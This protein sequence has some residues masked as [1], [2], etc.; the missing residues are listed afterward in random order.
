MTTIG[1]VKR[2]FVVCESRLA[3]LAER[4]GPGLTPEMRKYLYIYIYLHIYIY[5]YMYINLPSEDT[6]RVV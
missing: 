1:D 5:I 6:G 4:P 2:A 3:V